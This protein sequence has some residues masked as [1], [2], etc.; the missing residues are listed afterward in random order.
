MK[1]PVSHAGNG[2][3]TCFPGILPSHCL[4]QAPG[5]NGMTPQQLCGVI[6]RER[7]DALLCFGDTNSALAAALTAVKSGVPVASNAGGP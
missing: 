4:V 6:R 3:F 7:P 2:G 1:I 5:K